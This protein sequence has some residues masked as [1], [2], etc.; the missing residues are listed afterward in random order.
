MHI[1]TWHP[2]PNQTNYLLFLLA[3][4]YLFLAFQCHIALY[5]FVRSLVNEVDMRHYYPIAPLPPAPPLKLNNNNDNNTNDN[6][7]VKC[8]YYFSWIGSMD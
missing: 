7:Q 3:L 6:N 1:A 4:L 8:T 2:Y 5:C